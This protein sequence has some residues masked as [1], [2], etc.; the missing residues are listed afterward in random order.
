MGIVIDSAGHLYVADTMN[1]RIRKITP[2]CPSG[3]VYST[4]SASC[5]TGT[6]GT[7]T[8][9]TTSTSTSTNSPKPNEAM[10]LFMP[11]SSLMNLIWMILR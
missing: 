10:N 2:T 7:T 9:S 3:Q 6:T 8:S 5:V 4:Q 11:F 1:R